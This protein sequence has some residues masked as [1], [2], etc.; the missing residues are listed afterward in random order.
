MEYVTFLL[1]YCS[2]SW[3]NSCMNL[4]RKSKIEAIT[5]IKAK[6]SPSFFDRNT[7]PLCFIKHCDF[8]LPGFYYHCPR[9]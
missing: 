3:A 5:L 1:V 8:L 6:P 9:T 2:K 7:T 4:T